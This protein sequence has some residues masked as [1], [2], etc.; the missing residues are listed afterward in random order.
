[1]ASSSESDAD[2]V[3]R[4]REQPRPKEELE[5]GY[6]A[7]PPRKRKEQ[8][9]E[10]PAPKVS[11]K[12]CLVR[13]CIIPV[14]QNARH[15]KHYHM[16]DFVEVVDVGTGSKCVE[17]LKLMCTLL[18][19]VS[20]HELVKLV[21]DKKLQ[22]DVPMAMSP[23]DKEVINCVAKTLN[24]VGMRETCI[25]KIEQ[26]CQLIHWSS[27]VRLVNYMTENQRFAFLLN[28]Q[29]RKLSKKSERRTSSLPVILFCDMYPP[30]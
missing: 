18:G 10:Q 26:C 6:W 22:S 19:L 23:K 3:W 2:V 27:V 12:Q 15:V 16:P 9:D 29:Q 24:E 5:R 11:G 20:L 7:T 17:F 25:K 8:S 28:F 1:M 14:R 13:S 30:I 21:S 4:R